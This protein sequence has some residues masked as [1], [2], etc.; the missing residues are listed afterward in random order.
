[1]GM[2]AGLV[3]SRTVC[4]DDAGFAP[5]PPALLCCV[6]S[7]SDDAVG[8]T[9]TLPSEERLELGR[10]A[11]QSIT[12]ADASK[13]VPGIGRFFRVRSP[14]HCINMNRQS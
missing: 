1:M 11:L 8:A 7:A 14:A 10:Q 13:V 4:Q 3:S 5:N 2:Q 6:K 12:Q 9:G